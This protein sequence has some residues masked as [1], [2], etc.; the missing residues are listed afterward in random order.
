LSRKALRAAID[1]A[2]HEFRW[3]FEVV[4]ALSKGAKSETIGRSILDFQPRLFDTI[5]DLEKLYR[6][7]KREEKR[8]IARKGL[9]NFA[10]FKRRMATLA[11]YSKALRPVLVIGRAIGDGFAWLFYERDRE[12]IAEHLKHQSQPLLPSDLGG[13]GERL[14]VEGVQ[15]LG[16]Y[17]LI[18]HGTTTFLRMGDISFID[19]KSARVACVGELKTR[20]INNE[21]ISVEMALVAGI[22]TFSLA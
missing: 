14:T 16:G 4:T 22:E 9:L 20:R 2:E 6:A 18:Y 13:L 21:Q 5:A 1:V 17:L 7:I 19:P 15:G 8:L 3:C 10:W 11:S 12:L